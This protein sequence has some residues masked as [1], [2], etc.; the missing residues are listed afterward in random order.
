MDFRKF[1]V[2]GLAGGL[3]YFVV[4]LVFSFLVQLVLH[5]DVMSLGG[6]R[7]VDDPV[8]LLFFLSPWVYGFALALVY[9]KL[10]RKLECGCVVWK[11]KCFGLL[12]W[13]VIVVPSTFVVYTSMTYPLGF[14][15]DQLVGGL[16]EMLAAGVVISKLME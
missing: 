7:A 14:T 3:A 11:G 4:M 2:A 1:L 9:D 12:M 5:Y 10:G 15:V 8:M 13:L 6:M 16:F